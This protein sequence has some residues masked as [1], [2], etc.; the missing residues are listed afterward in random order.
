MFY[1]N[2][3]KAFVAVALVLL[4][5]ACFTQS[6]QTRQNTNWAYSAATNRLKPDYK[7][8]H[9][10]A[11]ST[12]ILFGIKAAKLLFA[13]N[14]KGFTANVSIRYELYNNLGDK[15]PM[16]T[17]NFIFAYLSPTDSNTVLQGKFK[18]K[19]PKGSKGIAQ[20]KLTDIN[21]GQNNTT[22]V[23]ID[24]SNAF[25]SQNYL[26]LSNPDSALIYTSYI[27]KTQVFNV[28][29]NNPADSVLYVKYYSGE[30]PLPAPPFAENLDP[31]PPRPDTVFV[32]PLNRGLSGPQ[33]F[34]S[35]GL[36]VFTTNRQQEQGL[37]VLQPGGNFPEL[38]RPEDVLKPLRFLTSRADYDRMAAQVDVKKEVDDFWLRAAGNNARARE[39]LKNFYGGVRLANDLFTTTRE[40]WKTDRGMVFT[41][42][43]Q[44]TSA[45][46]GTNTETWTYSAAGNMRNTTFI[47]DRRPDGMAGYDYFLRRS[48]MFKPAWYNMVEN[49]R[50]GRLLYWY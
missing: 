45:Y 18:V 8:Y 14:T 27:S 4:L 50:N 34:V 32:L 7:V 12:T 2:I 40:G 23:D 49:W 39:V 38:T 13:N 25:N 28:L 24:K 22:F 48:D 19:L 20:L 11:D 17:A 44:P 33:Q 1:P 31:T 47:F 46:R 35:A 26:L 42:F 43:G 30:A 41:I 37:A 16:D 21:R 15:L 29:T 3:L 36:Y 9:S 6:V 10:S 5:S